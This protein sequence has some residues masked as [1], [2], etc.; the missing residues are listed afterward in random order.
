V[1]TS[2]RGRDHLHG[3]TQASLRQL[4]QVVER[5]ASPE[6]MARRA[7]K[8]LE[9]AESLQPQPQNPLWRV[10]GVSRPTTEAQYMAL[11]RKLVERSGQS[12]KDLAGRTEFDA[13]IE[14]VP[15]STI[16]G[17]IRRDRLPKR[18]D[19]LRALLTVLCDAND[20]SRADTEDLLDLRA[21]LIAARASAGRV[22]THQFAEPVAEPAASPCARC[23]RW[24][25]PFVLAGAASLVLVAAVLCSL[26]IVVA[27]HF[28][29]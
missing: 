2:P 16:Y 13:S 14:T 18:E 11:L 3:P 19:Q 8:L 21:E 1:T 27:F 15:R 26:L 17:V 4:A 12:Y 6:V 23:E 9:I 10:V 7:R 29:P 20:G 24:R 5:P 22:V 25:S 28:I